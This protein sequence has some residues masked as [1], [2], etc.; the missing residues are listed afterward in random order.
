[1]SSTFTVTTYNVL[2]S[3]RATRDRYPSLPESMLDPDQRLV[4]IAKYLQACNADILCL[5]EIDAY[6]AYQLEEALKPATYVRT[7]Y[8]SSVSDRGGCA[9]FYNFK[10]TKMLRITELNY[11]FFMAP[12][13]RVAL[14]M[15]LEVAGKALLVANTHVAWDAPGTAV[16][17]QVGPAQVYF[18]LG[19]ITQ[20]FP[21]S[22]GRIVCGGLNAEPDSDAVHLLTSAGYI[23]TH[24]EAVNK[25]T[26][27]AGKAVQIDYLFHDAA[28]RAEAV[29]HALVTDGSTLPNEQEPSDHV[30]V[31]AKFSWV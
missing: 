23:D 5:Q 2:A 15:E 8:E 11:D 27:H 25:A 12:T 20:N 31:S 19:A 29:P 4:A 17:Q 28:L 14:M 21:G 6:A 26:C 7:A 22:N 9:I 30:A 18:L 1:M 16:Q 3:S 10:T 24:S 13:A